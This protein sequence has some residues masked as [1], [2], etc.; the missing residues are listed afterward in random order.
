LE[1][2]LLRPP[3][4]K[5]RRTASSDA[6]QQ[7][8][9]GNQ[10]F[11][12]NS[13]ESFRR[14]QQAY[15]KAVTLDPAYAAAWAG[16]AMATWWVADSADSATA[17]AAGRDRAVA[18]AN[19]AIELAPDL[20][21]GYQARGFV[22]VPVQW[23]LEG[24]RA[25]LQK[26]LA[27]EPDNPETLSAYAYVVLRPLGQF[28]DAIQAL[29]RAAELDPLNAQLWGRLGTVLSFNDQF[30][31]AREA[32]N[33]SLELSPHQSFTPFNLGLTYLMERKPDVAKAIN[34]RS[35]NEIFRLTR[36]ALSEYD[37]GHA[38]ES[39]QPLDEL[40]ARFGHSGAYQIAQIYARRGDKDRAFDWLKRAWVQRDGGL[41]IVKVD[42]LLRQLHDDPRFAEILKSVHLPVD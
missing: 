30:A 38:K 29:R 25:D 26:A 9:Q 4:T 6:H 5:D 37:L 23:D 13:V 31:A 15:E 35:T 7:Y 41:V 42:P 11:H 14:A 28:P 10:F 21:D 22:R 17:M 34:A 12:L 3:T 27:L 36:L 20:P 32:F 24:A 33:R 8:L 39:Q 2:E 16:L 40:I 18:A 19:K 1:F